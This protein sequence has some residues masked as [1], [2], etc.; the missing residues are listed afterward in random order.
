MLVEL[1]KP[2]EKEL[3]QHRL[4]F[5]AG[6]ANSSRRDARLVVVCRAAEPIGAMA[7]SLTR[8]EQLEAAPA[9]S[10]LVWF[11]LYCIVSLWHSRLRR[12]IG[13]V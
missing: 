1:L 6:H 8:V 3:A 7:R 13:R 11:W 10:L 12:D 4:H 2:H 9:T 5:V